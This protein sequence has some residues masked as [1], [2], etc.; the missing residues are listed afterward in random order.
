MSDSQ[1]STIMVTERVAEPGF[2]WHP[3]YAGKSY[4]EVRTTLTEDIRRDQRSYVFAMDAAESAENDSLSMVVELERRWSPFEFDWT[5]MDPVILADRILA[6]EQARE[7]AQEMFPFA[8]YRSSGRLVDDP[9]PDTAIQE[10]TL[11]IMK[12]GIVI[13]VLLLLIFIVAVIL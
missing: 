1:G 9:A 4:T 2:V 5:E 7:A 11:P 10:R 8:D 13:L 3:I 6:F 12:I